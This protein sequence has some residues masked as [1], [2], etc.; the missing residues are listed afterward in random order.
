MNVTNTNKI[1]D[2]QTDVRT[3]KNAQSARNFAIALLLIF[4]IITV[5]FVT[6]FKMG[7]KLFI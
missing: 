1:T 7:A 6:I 4:F 5:Y 3:R 2:N